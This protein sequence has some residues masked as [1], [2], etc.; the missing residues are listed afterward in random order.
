MPGERPRRVLKAHSAVDGMVYSLV[1]EGSVARLGVGALKRHLQATTGVPTGLQILEFHGEALE[2][3][4]TCGYYGL[5]DGCMLQLDAAPV[6][7]AGAVPAP[8]VQ[9]PQLPPMGAAMAPPPPHHGGD[10]YGDDIV[11]A[12]RSPPRMPR[13]PRA[14]RLPPPPQQQQQQQHAAGA[15]EDVDYELRRL[16]EVERQLRERE[17]LL[18]NEE[19][20]V[21]REQRRLR[22]E[23]Q[24]VQHELR[25]G[26]GPPQPQ[27]QPHARPLAPLDVNSG[28]YTQSVLKPRAVVSPGRASGSKGLTVA[29]LMRHNS[30]TG[31][32]FPHAPTPKTVDY[33]DDD[34]LITVEEIPRPGDFTHTPHVNPPRPGDISYR[35]LQ[36]PCEPTVPLHAFPSATPSDARR[37]A[38]SPGLSHQSRSGTCR[39]N[40]TFCDREFEIESQYRSKIAHFD[41]QRVSNKQHFDAMTKLLREKEDQIARLEDEV[42]LETEFTQQKRLIVD[43]LKSQVQQ[44]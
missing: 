44:G 30:Q 22:D 11:T 6:G 16:R 21:A 33:G 40:L 42:H 13:S 12:Q 35:G 18:Q 1:F 28:P 24:K 37:G 32:S 15:D 17:A 2:E 25:V 41:Q 34:D 19:A 36:H 5:D 43:M 23:Q 39:T 31:L 4:R 10:G 9:P 14:G 26:A 27:V 38:V 7:G 3:G 8:G 20:S 29:D